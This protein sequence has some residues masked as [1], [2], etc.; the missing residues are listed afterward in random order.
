MIEESP[1]PATKVTNELQRGWLSSHDQP[2][3]LSCLQLSAFCPC[4]S[5]RPWFLAHRFGAQRHERGGRRQAFHI[6][7]R[8][9]HCL[10]NVVLRND[11]VAIEH[12]ASV[13]W[14]LIF[15]ATAGS[16]SARTMFRT[17]ARLKSYTSFLSSPTIR[18]AR[19]QA[20]RKSRSGFPFRW[21]IRRQSSRRAFNRLSIIVRTSP[22]KGNDPSSSCLGNFG[23]PGQRADLPWPHS[24]S[25]KPVTKVLQT[26]IAKL[27]NDGLKISPFK[28]A[29]PCVVFR[30]T[31]EDLKNI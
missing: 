17:A 19:A 5:W 4:S 2:L 13:R 6:R 21:K 16:P 26:G 15:I 31:R 27:L 12:V 11:V 8:L 9:Q 23:F 1:P 10:S 22:A 18:Q 24:R 30:K 20:F 28:E 25:I 3:F 7:I 29:L 14:P